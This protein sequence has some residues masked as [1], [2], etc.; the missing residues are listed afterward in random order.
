M[1][2]A[3]SNQPLHCW[4]WLVEDKAK[5]DVAGAPDLMGFYVG[6]DKF[7]RLQRRELLGFAHQGE[8]K[9]YQYSPWADVPMELG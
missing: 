8:H 4:R 5:V 7:A 1:S 6:E 9:V 3:V 2:G